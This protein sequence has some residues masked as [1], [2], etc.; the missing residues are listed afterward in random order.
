MLRV[1][2]RKV[3]PDKVE[4]LT[5]WLGELNGPRRD[6]ALATLVDEGCRHETAV[7]IQG[8]DGPVIVYVMEVEDDEAS[9]AAAASSTHPVDVDHKRV[10]GAALADRVEGQVLLD[11]RP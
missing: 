4:E 9:R 6:E 10:M 7:L 2:I 8:Q 5:A 1:S 3:H 11:L